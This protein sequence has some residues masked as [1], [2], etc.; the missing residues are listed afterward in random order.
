MSM[1]ILFRLSGMA[2]I[3]GSTLAYVSWLVWHLF[4]KASGGWTGPLFQPM[5]LLFMIG[6]TVLLIGLPGLYAHQAQ[7]AGRLGLIAFVLAF[8][9]IVHHEIGTQPITTFV[10][11]FLEG[12]PDTKALVTPPP[13]FDE[14]LGPLYGGYVLGG[15]AVYFLALVLWGIATLRAR[16][17][18]RWAA[19]LFIAGPFLVF[20]PFTQNVALTTIHF[21]WVWCGYALARDV[22]PLQRASTP[23]TE[24]APPVAST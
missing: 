2:V 5:Q 16:V 9:A 1:R 21:A 13:F 22:E 17:F 15:L 7:Q 14:R 24:P 8:F 18:P 11:P 12:R 10:V 4:G 20:V 19:W 23:Y 3:I 6:F